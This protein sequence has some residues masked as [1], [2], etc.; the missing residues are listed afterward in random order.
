MY[1][2]MA[3]GCPDYLEVVVLPDIF[4]SQFSVHRIM[5]P[6]FPS[7]LPLPGCSVPV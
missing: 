6:Y 5:S 1:S 7:S 4:K 2:A 3:T